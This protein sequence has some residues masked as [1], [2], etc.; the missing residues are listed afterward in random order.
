MTLKDSNQLSAMDNK[1]DDEA[2][3]L[4]SALL[5]VKLTDPE[6][7]FTKQH[8]VLFDP[9]NRIEGEDDEI[10]DTIR[11]LKVNN[12]KET[13]S[14]FNKYEY[15]CSHVPIFFFLFWSSKEKLIHTTPDDL[16]ALEQLI[17]TRLDEGRGETLFEIGIE[18]N[19]NMAYLIKNKYFKLFVQFCVFFL[20]S[21]GN[22]YVI[23][24]I[25]VS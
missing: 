12:R 25:C 7:T 23:I 17:S 2:T 1:N 22:L 3:R 11:T 10:T 9:S 19:L 21:V 4:A 5:D 18:G 15:F 6:I 8:N 16:V 20:L 24:I 14:L 13:V